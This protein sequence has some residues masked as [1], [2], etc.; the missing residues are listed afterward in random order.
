MFWK[1]L[2]IQ[3]VSKTAKLFMCN[4]TCWTINMDF[5]SSALPYNLY[6]PEVQMLRAKYK[7]VVQECKRM[8]KVSELRR[9]TKNFN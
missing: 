6:N 3:L 5:Q 8:T 9:K 2:A 7:K 4:Y 1:T